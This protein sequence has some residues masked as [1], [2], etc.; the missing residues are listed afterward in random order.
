MISA[1]IGSSDEE[2]SEK[3]TVAGKQTLGK[4]EFFLT[5]LHFPGTV[6]GILCS[7]SEE[8]PCLDFQKP[9]ISLPNLFASGRDR[10]SLLGKGPPT[11]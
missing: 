2:A 9:V 3:S 8:H 7:Q 10:L 4:C 5:F 6:K 11:I 1:Y